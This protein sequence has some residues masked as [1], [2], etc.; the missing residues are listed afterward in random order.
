[1]I[2]IM[3]YLKYIGSFIMV[4]FITLTSC[5]M[6]DT[7]IDPTRPVDV[8]LNLI[9]PT[10]IGQA[11][12]NQMAVPARLAGIVIQHYRGFDAQQVAYTDYVIPDNTF[13]NYWN[14]GAYGGVMKDARDLVAKADDEDQ[15]H[16]KG[17][18]LI[19][20]AE[21]LGYLAAAFG[22]VP[23]QDALLGT[24]NLKPSFDAQRDVYDDVIAMLDEAITELQKA[25]VPGGP[26][27]DDLIYGGDAS[28][29]IKT[30]NAYKARYLMHLGRT[31]EAQTAIN[32][33]FTSASEEPVFQWSTNQV[34][35]N[36]LARFGIERPNTLI[37]DPRFGD[38]LKATSDPRRS[39]IIDDP[40]ADPANNEQ[41]S[42]YSG[43]NPD[44]IW[45]QNNSAIPLISLTELKFYEAEISL[46]LADLQDAVRESMALM[47][48][49]SDDA[50]DYIAANVQSATL[51]DVM[52]EAYI[53][54]YGHASSV[55]WHNYRRTGFPVLTPSSS[56]ANGLNPSGV[57][58]RRW[59]YPIGERNTNE[60]N[61]LAAISAQGWSADVLDSP[62]DIFK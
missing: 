19:L 60:E 5:D 6:T 48:V 17:I 56:G 11:A 46:S 10:A 23:S 47:G 62:T 16:Y 32:N 45:A 41:Y 3:K 37:I 27:G 21:S 20:K 57:I 28:G 52:N 8:E 33:S 58:P 30:A 61:L 44:L 13:N 29:W 7:N 34:N 35:A 36:P 39:K 55:V 25:A 9:L 54:L 4:F 43:S 53:A 15:P 38:A 14:T 12:Y 31:A 59:I 42:F 40:D 49:A 18:A 2:N 51:E 26:A 22:D 50:E 24:E 1:M